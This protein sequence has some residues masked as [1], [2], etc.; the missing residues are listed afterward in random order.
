MH[1]YSYYLVPV[2]PY[3]QNL[4]PLANSQALPMQLGI[5]SSNNLQ[6]ALIQQQMEHNCQIHKPS[7][8]DDPD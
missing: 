8:T 5:P 2:Y 1:Q 3:T 6:P 4:I 7:S